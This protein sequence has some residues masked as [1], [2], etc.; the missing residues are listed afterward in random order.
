[1]LNTLPSISASY[2]AYSLNATTRCFEG[3]R[4]QLISDI[5]SW[6]GGRQDEG[7]SVF[8]LNG[9]AGIGK[10]TVARTVSAFADEQRILGASFFF[11][12][13]DGRTNPAIFF[14][15]IAFQLAHVSPAFKKV[16]TDVIR[17][18]PL[19]SGAIL[20]LQIRKLIVEPLQNLDTIPSPVVIIVDAL[21]EC[22]ENGAHD[23]LVQLLTH[24][25]SLPSFKVLVTSRPEHYITRVFQKEKNLSKIVMHDIDASIAQ[26]D[27]KIYLLF[28]FNQVTEVLPG[29][30][31]FWEEHEFLFLV[32]LT[33]SLFIYAVTA[34]QFIENV[35]I[36]NPRRQ[37]ERLLKGKTS[38]NTTSTPFVQLDKLY[39][40]VVR[41]S[42]P[43]DSED[44]L[45]EQFR[46]VVG[47]VIGLEEP[48]SLWSIEK[49]LGLERGAARAALVYLPSVIAV[50]DTSDGIPRV[51]HPSFPDYIT[52][53]KRCKHPLLVI[54]PHDNHLHILTRCFSLMSSMLKRN[55][56]DIPRSA[57]LNS[58]VE[59]LDIKVKI[60]I[61]AWLRYAVIRWPVHLA[62]VPP[63]NEGAMACMERFCLKNL[64]H[65]IEA[66]ALLGE[67]NLAIPLIRQARDWAVSQHNFNHLLF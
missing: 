48:L 25:P 40:Q 61:P 23:I 55:I 42:V 50:P 62:A 52:N 7:S 46:T 27:I 39:D 57:R 65:W 66:C 17:N 49:L 58:E 24:L 14:T 67:L 29:C 59:G 37:L 56:C 19:A 3:T 18:D 15:T 9:I 53:P 31:W 32:M 8:W 11:S 12:R 44:E 26:S 45:S 1:M 63:E 38:A 43:P 54:H 34:M 33:G 36:Q 13:T 5:K 21:D 10:S 30:D 4:Q 6:L 28:R 41:D 2:D 60:A 64:L 47:A 51:Y 16:I 35:R 20:P 22:S